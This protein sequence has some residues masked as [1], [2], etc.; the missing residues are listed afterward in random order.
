MK[1]Y[2]GVIGEYTTEYVIER[3]RFITT[4]R[5]V[6]CEDEAKSFVA[7]IKKKHSLA[8]HNCYA[9]VADEAGLIR[10]FSDDGEP[11]G[12]AGMP[13][14]EVLKNRNLGKTAVVVTR[15]FGG[16]KL[17]AG[18]LVRAYSRAAV[19]GIN[20]AKKAEFIY[21]AR[22]R[23]SLDYERYS[24]FLKFIV[25]RKTAVEN[26]EF[27][28]GVTVDIAVPEELSKKFAAEISDYFNGKI[29]IEN[30]GNKF[31]PFEVL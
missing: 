10:K 31:Y 19:D 14:L 25:G 16:V 23:L 28:D 18:G 15:Y 6:G 8:T 4:V 5:E 26:V 30:N 22:Y 11:Q 17:G 12:T 3:S 13:I 24:G 20:G 7:E 27:S 1:S 2:T 9:Y 21:S 29:N